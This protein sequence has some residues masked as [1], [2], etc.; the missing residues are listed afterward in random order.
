MEKG[1]DYYERRAKV[2]KRIEKRVEREKRKKN[3][4]KAKEYKKFLANQ[5]QDLKLQKKFHRE[6]ESYRIE[7][8]RPRMSWSQQ[9][10]RLCM[11]HQM[12]VEFLEDINELYQQTNVEENIVQGNILNE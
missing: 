6:W 8:D 11:D 7:V 2:D 10:I 9:T 4:Y 1:N 3:Y 5:K 12:D